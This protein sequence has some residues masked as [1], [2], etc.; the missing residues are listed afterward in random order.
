MSILSNID[1]IAIIGMACRV[2]GAVNPEQLWHNLQKGITSVHFFNDEELR[3]RNVPEALVQNPNYVKAEAMPAEIDCFDAEFFGYTA[4]EATIMDPQQRLM[5][6]AAWEALDHAGYPPGSEQSVGVF[7]S[8]ATSTYINHAPLFANLTE[9]FYPLFISNGQDFLPTRISYKLDI[10][11]PSMLVQT[12]CSSSLVAVHQACQSLLNGECTLALAGGVSI[13][14]SQMPG[15]FYQ[16][17][18][19]ASPDGHCY[20]FDERAQGTIFGH[21]LGMVVLK[22]A[23][24]ALVDGDQIIA[25]IKAS[26]VN[27]DG[28]AKMGYTAPSAEGQAQ[29]IAEALEVAGWTADTVSYVET[30]GTGTVLGDPIE[31]AG[32]TAA[33]RET[34]QAHSFCAI[35]SIKPNIGHLDVASG[36]L[37]LIKTAL[38]LKH[39]QLV[40]H[41]HFRTA[42]PDIYFEE[43]PFF[44]NTTLKDWECSKSLRRAG[45]SSFGIGGTNAH[46]VVEE[47]P[48]TDRV[49]LDQHSPPM[50]LAVS[51]KSI[52]SLQMLVKQYEVLLENDTLLDIQG[53]C[54]SA[55]TRK[56]HFTYRLAVVGSTRE[57]LC[58]Q[59]Q[60]ARSKVQEISTAAPKVAFVFTG[61]GSQ[62]PGMAASLYA[63]SAVFRT[64]L[65]AVVAQFDP[66]LPQPLGPLLLDPATSA[67]SLEQTELAQPALFALG[68]ALTALW[69]ACGVTPTLVLGHS[70][71]EY[72]AATLA[73]V[74]SLPDAVRVVA[75][76]ARLMQALPA[77]GSMVR[78]TATAADLQPLLA[79][80]PRLSIAAYNAPSEVVV[81]GPTADVTIFTHQAQ[82]AGYGYRQLAVSH[83][84]H[85][86]LM[87]PMQADFAAVAAQVTWHVPRIPLISNQTGTFADATIAAAGYW[88]EHIR[89]PVQFARSLATAA[90]AG[91]THWI[92]LG[93]K[94]A[95]STLIRATFGE[96]AVVLPSLRPADTTTHTFLSSLARLYSDGYNLNWQEIVSNAPQNYTPCPRYPFDR[97]RYWLNQDDRVL[98]SQLP[99]QAEELS[100]SVVFN[101]PF[102]QQRLLNASESAIYNGKLSVGTLPLL[103]DHVIHNEIVMA[104]AGFL[105]MLVA[106]AQEH[107]SIPIEFENIVF[108]QLLIVDT[109]NTTDIQLIL[110][111]DT[112]NQMNIKIATLNTDHKWIT[113]LKA[114]DVKGTYN[115]QSSI[116]LKGLIE[117]FPGDGKDH[118]EFYDNVVKDCMRFGPSF[119]WIKTAWYHD[120]E[121]LGLVVAPSVTQEH[122]FEVHPGLIDSCIGLLH[123]VYSMNLS[124]FELFIPMSIEH[125]I[126]YTIPQDG[127]YIHATLQS[128]KHIA[129]TFTGSVQVINPDG[130]LALSLVEISMRRTQKDHLVSLP[131]KSK[132]DYIYRL[133]WESVKDYQSITPLRKSGHWLIFASA[134]SKIDPLL[135]A[136]SERGDS[137][138]LISSTAEIPDDRWDS[139]RIDWTSQ[140]SITDLLAT[141]QKQYPLTSWHGIIHINIADDQ[142]DISQLE[143]AQSKGV[144]HLLL[145]LQVLPHTIDI[146]LWVITQQTQQVNMDDQIRVTHAPIWGLGRMATR[147]SGTLRLQLVDID[148]DTLVKQTSLSMLLHLLDSNKPEPEWALRGEHVYN[149]RLTENFLAPVRL[150]FRNDAAYLITGGLGGLGLILVQHIVNNGGRHIVL[151]SRSTPGIAAR[152]QIEELESSG[153]HITIVQGDVSIDK[154]VARVFTLINTMLP[155][156]KGV[157]H[158]AGI[159]DDGIIAQQTWERYTRVMAPKVW[160]SWLLH[161][162]SCKLDLDYFILFSSISAIVTGA[163]QSNYAAANAFM[164]SLSSF[165]QSQGLPALSI[166]WGAWADIGMAATT[167]RQRSN[168]TTSFGQLNPSDGLAALDTLLISRLN[169]AVVVPINRALLAT[170]ELGQHPLFA[171]MLPKT[172]ASITPAIS[173]PVSKLDYVQLSRIVQQSIN[174]II[175]LSPDYQCELHG[176]LKEL[177]FDSLSGI[178]LRNY[179]SKQLNLKLSATLIFDYPTLHELVEYLYKLSHP[180]EEPA[181]TSLQSTVSSPST[182]DYTNL[183]ESELLDLLDQELNSIDAWIEE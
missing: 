76:R 173:S 152:Q 65:D 142:V 31:I 52:K 97:K 114:M 131:E 102:L 49:I 27:N 54:W 166:N 53:L 28:G 89:A 66:L 113:H 183:S 145:L 149:A 93:P 45:V 123:S 178:E 141:Q 83:A 156:L 176:S 160:G 121:A 60:K 8:S 91:C 86:G 7:I 80:F 109:N 101:H 172:K 71:G 144:R 72:L 23:E 143:A 82:Q 179:L 68:V 175:G 6:E 135:R 12:A 127:A 13:R 5:L 163:G 24:Q 100:K 21:G 134:V 69:R 180:V 107:I 139:I 117:R 16:Q 75:A 170:S 167:Q 78:L 10:H 95:L 120:N 168:S 25:I 84:F 133:Q 62:Y 136:L 164:D 92:E 119:R 73:G 161:E 90:A 140:Q 29:V 157:F 125:F 46:I 137:W 118:S 67:A 124:D 1:G 159:L 36:V 115:L 158:A 70:L 122:T 59:L 85:S 165:R 88:V 112:L 116:N 30:H 35:G 77:D 47:A 74:L 111:P 103:A 15:Y 138:T 155:P 3:A 169:N 39:R 4:R 17:G 37:G 148:Q 43:T 99:W 44:V 177:G 2:P 18:G 58:L 181:A 40:P 56:N 33:F 132:L 128:H 174:H 41:L 162:Y 32:L 20:A 87:E 81:A 19:T 63:S 130:S 106:T 42:N 151:L 150:K 129:E 154:D 94:P 171:R 104:G 153:A 105:S 50:I 55:A 22:S 79:S 126:F 110:T 9:Q 108:T 26:A 57:D 147:E 34:T 98:L 38:Q 51:A 146:P 96:T 64:A 61:Q 48:Q 14:V 11:G 182:S